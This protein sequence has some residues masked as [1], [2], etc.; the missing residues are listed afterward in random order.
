[1]TMAALRKAGER[2]GC[3]RAGLDAIVDPLKRELR[4]NPALRE[5][6]ELNDR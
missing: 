2:T 6:R 3:K 1:M 4:I 5:Q